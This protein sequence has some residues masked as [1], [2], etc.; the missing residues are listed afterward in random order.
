MKILILDGYVDEPTC[1]GVPPF[2]STYIRYTAGALKLGGIGQIDYAT[3][4]M[5]RNT[6]FLFD[7]YPF[8]VLI[9][10]NPVPGKYLG[11]KPID[12]SEIFQLGNSNP[13]TQFFIGGPIQFETLPELPKNMRLVQDDIESFLFDYFSASK[14]ASR[15]RT[16]DE[17]NL[18]SREGAFILEQHPRFPDII[19]EIETGRGCPRISHCSFCIEGSFPVEFR[20]PEAVIEEIKA[21]RKTGVTR[22]RIGK[23]ADIFAYGSTLKEWKNGFSRPN[24]EWIEKLYSGIREA[25]PDLA[26]LHLDNANPGTL[27]QFPTESEKIAKIITQ[28]NTAGDVAAFGMESADPQVIAGQAT[29]VPDVRVVPTLEASLRDKEAVV[30]SRDVPEES[31]LS[32]HAVELGETGASRFL[33][34]LPGDP[35]VYDRWQLEEEGGRPALAEAPA[36]PPLPAMAV[37]A[38]FGPAGGEDGEEEDA[39]F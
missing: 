19:A 6:R 21:L 38:L 11:G 12:T 36:R 24:P 34:E 18:F 26:M 33:E 4:E 31:F 5:A 17:I 29:V 23:Q 13:K 27:A 3:V 25:V 28:Y 37:P 7:S 10:G 2:V 30:A 39:P 1:L 14:T 9:A 22:F 35:P 32:R 20:Q 16:I 15:R 8:I